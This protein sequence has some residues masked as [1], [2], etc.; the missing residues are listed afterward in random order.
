[1]IW[2]LWP[3]LIEE[4][5]AEVVKYY[6]ALDFGWDSNSTAINKALWEKLSP[7]LRDAVIKASR[8]AEERN[9]EAQRRSEVEHRKK[10]AALGVQIYFPTAQERDLW[11]Q[12]ANM[13]AIWAELADPWLKSI[14]PVK[15]C[16]GRF[17]LSLTESELR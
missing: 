5:H 15:R 6:T 2:S 10:V 3:S 9:S 11:R 8:I 16:P 1:M 7:D 13:P 4:R 12:K 14:I 17:W